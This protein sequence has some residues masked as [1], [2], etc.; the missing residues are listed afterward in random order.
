MTPI[1]TSGIPELAAIN[2]FRLTISK[3]DTF[4]FSLDGCSIHNRFG[5]G[6]EEIETVCEL[7]DLSFD[8]HM[9]VSCR[10]MPAAYE[11]LKHPRRLR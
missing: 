10:I 3:G 4:T 11:P 7:K 2:A 5:L 1:T 6:G 8:E 9:V